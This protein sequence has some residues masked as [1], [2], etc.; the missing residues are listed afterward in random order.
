M[1]GCCRCVAEVFRE[2]EGEMNDDSRGFVCVLA[3][4]VVFVG[5]VLLG[6]WAAVRWMGG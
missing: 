3:V 2:G 4:V 1:L 5:I 6:L